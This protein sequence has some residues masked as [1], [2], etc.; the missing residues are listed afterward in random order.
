MKMAEKIVGKNPKVMA[1][2]SFWTRIR[3]RFFVK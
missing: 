1:C 3:P 2:P